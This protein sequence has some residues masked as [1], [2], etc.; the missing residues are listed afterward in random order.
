MEVSLV[1]EP[2]KTSEVHFNAFKLQIHY[3]TWD[4]EVGLTEFSKLVG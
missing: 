4:I 3:G 2:F 1:R